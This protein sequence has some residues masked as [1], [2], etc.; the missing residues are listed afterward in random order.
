MFMFFLCYFML[1]EF[2]G[3]M[4]SKHDNTRCAFLLVVIADVFDATLTL[5]IERKTL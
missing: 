2:Y 3:K 1:N 4:H 5:P